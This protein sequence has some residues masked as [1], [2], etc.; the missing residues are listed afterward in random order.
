MCLGFGYIECKDPCVY[1]SEGAIYLGFNSVGFDHV[2]ISSTR[3]LSVQCLISGHLMTA[4]ELLSLECGS[5]TT[6]MLQMY[7][8]FS[9]FTVS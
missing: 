7:V 3:S 8:H 2:W 6:E 4:L 5:T 9:K 1:D